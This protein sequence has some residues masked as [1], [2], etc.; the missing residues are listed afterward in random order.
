MCKEA[1]GVVKVGDEEENEE[2]HEA[3]LEDSGLLLFPETIEKSID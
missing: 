3:V 1:L 2:R